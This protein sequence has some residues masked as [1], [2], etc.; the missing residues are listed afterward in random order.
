MGLAVHM[1]MCT[2]HIGMCTVSADLTV[3]GMKKWEK[4]GKSDCGAHGHV[5]AMR[6]DMCTRTHMME[7]SLKSHGFGFVVF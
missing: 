7:E 6:T 3:W 2:V 4:M 1:G 5:H